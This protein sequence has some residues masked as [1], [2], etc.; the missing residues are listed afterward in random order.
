MRDQGHPITY[1]ILENKLSSAETMERHSLEDT[2][3][4][5]HRAAA[6]VEESGFDRQVWERMGN[7]DLIHSRVKQ[8]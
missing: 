8:G 7:L 4:E 6:A 1:K 5:N 2:T 3:G